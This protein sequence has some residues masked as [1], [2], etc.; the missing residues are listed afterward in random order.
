MSINRRQVVIFGLAAAVAGPS[1]ASGYQDEIVAALRAQGYQQITIETTFLGRV[2]ITALRQSNLREIVINPRTGEILRDLW[3]TP[4]GRL[5][6]SDPDFDDLDLKD[7]DDDRS[8]NSGSD[9]NRADNNGSD[10]RGSV[11]GRSDG[12]SD[13]SGSGRD[14]TDDDA[15][16]DSGSSSGSG[17]SGSD[18]ESGD[19]SGGGRD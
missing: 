17:N 8:D 16:D 11:D 13:N 9:D 5:A 14:D 12:G 3:L 4:D 15:S 18:D 10:A 7:R 6:V 1:F 19:D 2:R